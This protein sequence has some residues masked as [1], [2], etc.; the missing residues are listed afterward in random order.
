MPD[1]SNRKAE[2]NCSVAKGSENWRSSLYGLQT[3]VN[4]KRRSRSMSPT[5]DNKDQMERNEAMYVCLYHDLI[6][7][8]QSL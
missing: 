1:R 6:Y 8:R 2:R 3:P 4:Q 7:R 5:T